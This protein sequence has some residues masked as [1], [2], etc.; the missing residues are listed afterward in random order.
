M[1]EVSSFSEILHMI[2]DVLHGFKRE[3]RSSPDMASI[4]FPK[5]WSRRKEA[6]TI[7]TYM[8]ANYVATLVL[9]HMFLF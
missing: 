2:C 9:E 6:R 4:G 5:R 8:A 3:L 1:T 7:C